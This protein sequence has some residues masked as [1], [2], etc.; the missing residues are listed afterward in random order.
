[1]TGEALKVEDSQDRPLR[2]IR[3]TRADGNAAPSVFAKQNRKLSFSDLCNGLIGHIGVEGDRKGRHYN[4]A[5]RFICSGG[6]IPLSGEMSRSDKRVAV[7]LRMPPPYSKR[8]NLQSRVGKNRP[9]RMLW[10]SCA[11]GNAAP[12]DTTLKCRATSP[13]TSDGGG[14]K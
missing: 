14:F 3:K 8:L 5:Y 10:K 7:R 12:S 2:M 1:M 9:L 13:K 4:I 6:E 11:V